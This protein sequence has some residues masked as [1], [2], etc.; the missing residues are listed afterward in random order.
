MRRRGD[1]SRGSTEIEYLR[2]LAARTEGD[3]PMV[4][5]CSGDNALDERGSYARPDRCEGAETGAE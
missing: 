2:E 3:C 5:Y 1:G 4:A